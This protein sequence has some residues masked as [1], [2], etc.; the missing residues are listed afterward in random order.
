MRVIIIGCGKLGYR[1]AETFSNANYNV[2]V[3]DR[4]KEIVNK[5]NEALD[6]MAIRYNGFVV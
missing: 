4:E 2:I 6:V 5:V 1:I 3:I